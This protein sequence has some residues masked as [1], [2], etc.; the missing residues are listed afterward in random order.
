MSISIYSKWQAVF[1][2]EKCR[3]RIVFWRVNEGMN[4]EKKMTIILF[5][6]VSTQNKVVEDFA[7]AFS[8]SR[9]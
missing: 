8:K 4:Q 5:E 7:M 6:K 3:D 9:R 1:S 2:I